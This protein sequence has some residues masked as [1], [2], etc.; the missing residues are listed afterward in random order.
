MRVSVS[1]LANHPGQVS[2]IY[3]KSHCV[4]IKISQQVVLHKVL[5]NSGFAPDDIGNLLAD[6]LYSLK[7]KT[8][9]VSGFFCK[10]VITPK[11]LFDIPFKGIKNL[12]KGI[13]LPLCLGVLMSSA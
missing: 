11:D 10:L 12:L 8:S 9:R 13:I 7:I 6:D 2:S 5:E 3:I 1:Q 4:G